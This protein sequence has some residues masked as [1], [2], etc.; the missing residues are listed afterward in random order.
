MA[1]ETSV[2]DERGA[3]P[4]VVL[5]VISALGLVVALLLIGWNQ[6]QSWDGASVESVGVRPSTG[7]TEPSPSP[8]TPSSAAASTVVTYPVPRRL[9]IPAL[10]V[11]TRIVPVGLDS[12]DALEIPE[13]VDL[14]GW[15]E[16]GVPPGADLGSAVLVA[17]RDGREQGRGVFYDLGQLDVGDRVRVRNDADD[18]LA[19][20]VVSREAIRKKGLPYDELFAVDGPA[21]LTLISCGG[22]YDPDR[23]GYQDNI[24]VTAV[25]E[26]SGG[27]GLG[28]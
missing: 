21:R 18:V 27:A 8:S 26:G 19:Y 24:V 7:G 4:A 25:P 22:Y 17:H 12:D 10:D 11:D 20:V 2:G 1:G 28:E 14:V 6:W 13:D 16:L 9:M 3:A 23:G 15:Y 5:A